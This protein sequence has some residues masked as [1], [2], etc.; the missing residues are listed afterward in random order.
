[1][2]KIYLVTLNY[3]YDGNSV[4]KVFSKKMKALDYIRS[5]INIKSDDE[6]FYIEDYVGKGIYDIEE[7]ELE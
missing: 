6:D 7:K 2:E 5:I 3:Q 1:M 4:E